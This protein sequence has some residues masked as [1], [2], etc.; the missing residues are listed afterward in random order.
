MVVSDIYPL[1]KENF[2]GKKGPSIKRNFTML[3][4][5]YLQASFI[6]VETICWPLK[7]MILINANHDFGVS[8]YMLTTEN[9]IGGSS[10]GSGIGY[11]P[12]LL[13]TLPTIVTVKTESSNDG[14]ASTSYGTACLLIYPTKEE[15]PR[16]SIL[17]GTRSH[18]ELTWTMG[19]PPPPSANTP[20]SP[21][22]RTG[23]A[24]Q[25][26]LILTTLA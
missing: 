17:S 9:Q 15:V 24:G 21:I 14:T 2:F 19:V 1:K 5:P 25:C 26:K 4:L 8:N 3:L 7:T 6:S 20:R 22:S 16:S 23:S 12:S 10:T 13:V 11:L 18:E